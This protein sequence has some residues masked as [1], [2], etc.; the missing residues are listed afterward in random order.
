MIPRTPFI[1]DFV[2]NTHHYY[3]DKYCF[4]VID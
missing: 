2:I 4:C 1:R 3:T